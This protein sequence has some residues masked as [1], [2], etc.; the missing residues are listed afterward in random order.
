MRLSHTEIAA[1]RQ[2]S[3]C[4]L[5]AIC[6][7]EELDSRSINDQRGFT[8]IELIMA[9]VIVGILAVFV[10]SSFNNT[11]FQAR[12]FADQ[13]QTSLRY[14]QKVALAQRRNACVTT[15]AS[16][17]TLTIA[18]SSGAA[19]LCVG[20]LAFPAGGNTIKAPNGVT[21]TPA[22][23]VTFDALGRT[24]SSRN[25]TVSDVANNIVVEAET[26]YVHSP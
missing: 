19:S 22:V 13:L 25:F 4:H 23:T 11:G 5:I 24:S 21:L 2:E 16:L 10:V 15:T 12:G 8:L 9:I 6:E 26:G 3:S 1:D 17:I 14:A 7:L 20:N 18:S